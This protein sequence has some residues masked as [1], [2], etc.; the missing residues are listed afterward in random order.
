MIS[1]ETPFTSENQGEML[2]QHLQEEPPRVTSLVPNCPIFVEDLIFRLLEKE[3]NDRIY[4]ALA[5][6][7]EIDD[8][9]KKVTEQRSVAADTLSAGPSVTR[10][11]SAEELKSILGQK[12]KKKK[13]RDKSPFYER[14][15]FLGLCLSLVVA[16]VVWTFLPE[17]ED[18]AL[19]RAEKLSQSDSSSDW[20]DSKASYENLLVRF[21][22]GRHSETA[23][24]MIESLEKR[25][26]DKEMHGTKRKKEGPANEV[27]KQYLA[28][29][30]FLKFGDRVTA[31]RKFRSITQLFKD[32][33]EYKTYL[34]LA[35]DQIGQIVNSGNFDEDYVAYLNQKLKEADSRFKKGMEAEAEEV[36]QSIKTL[37]RDNEEVRSQYAYAS[38]RLNREDPGTPP[39]AEPEPVEETN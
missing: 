27:E 1:G 25:I 32:V 6:Q 26:L 29:E 38:K 34:L 18:R 4:D 9:H 14:V 30:H 19:A 36:W 8:I 11:Q 21:P 23:H 12:K 39:W 33:G 5:L 13:K 37:Y 16:F 20:R 22:N 17:G 7:S 2:M 3:P 28:A 24:E 10:I 15:W 31:L 35:E